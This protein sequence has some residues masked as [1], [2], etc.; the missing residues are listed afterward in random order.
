MCVF[1]D[2]VQRY[3][4]YFAW[5]FLD[6]CSMG[7]RRPDV[8]FREVMQAGLKDMN[9]FELGHTM[10][11]ASLQSVVWKV[12]C[13]KADCPHADRWTKVKELIE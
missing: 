9:D 6:G 5:A 12:L 2:K 10:A 3:G 11:F 13:L 1:E 8:W 4:P 7:N